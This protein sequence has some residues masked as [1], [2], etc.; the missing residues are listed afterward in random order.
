[1]CYSYIAVVRDE[2]MVG[3]LNTNVIMVYTK[4]LKFVR[5]IGSH[6]DGPGQ[7]GEIQGVSSDEDG[8]V[9]VSDYYNVCPCV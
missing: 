9:Y 8:N 6:G 3:D 4:D 2:V 7:I 1:M 5:R